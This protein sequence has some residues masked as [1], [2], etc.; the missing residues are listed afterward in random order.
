MNDCFLEN[1]ALTMNLDNPDNFKQID[2]QNFLAEIDDLPNQLQSAWE[3]GKELQLP[4]EKN[5]SQI[6]IA[7]MGGSAIGADLLA[8]YVS[9][10][11]KV[12]VYVH[13][14]YSLPAFARSPQTLFIASSH[15]GNTEETLS[16]FDQ[17]IETGC[18]TLVITTGG[19]LVEKAVQKRIPVW[20]FRHAGP[21]RAAVGYSFGLLLAILNRLNLCPDPSMEIAEA[22]EI[23]KKQRE[24]LYAQSP[25]SQNLAKRLAGQ[26]VGRWVN[27]IGSD[28]L[29]PVAR[30][31]KTQINELAK[32]VAHFDPIPEADHNMLVGI[33][34][35]DTIQSHTMTIFLRA[36]SDYLRNRF[37]SEI[38]QELLLREGLNTDT[39]Y[40]RGNSPISNMWSTL[41][42]GDYVSFYLAI[43]Y[44]TDPTP[45]LL[46]EQLK[47]ELKKK[48]TS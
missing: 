16:S 24:Q 13:R 44:K 1:G 47:I 40:A 43:A 34:N 5:I 11:C 45:I 25:V 27:I 31:W 4:N 19:K 18:S 15:S 42:I 28:Y 20:Q 41:Q 23:M 6:V 48:G 7:G 8:A 30:R 32:A 37:R 46:V 17:A 9:P 39:V 22:V 26:L 14:D 21:P 2:T 38:T 29:S 33:I 3:L 10:I 35:P 12:P 36:S